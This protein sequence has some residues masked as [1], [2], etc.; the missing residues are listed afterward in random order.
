MD[1]LEH[2]VENLI[3]PNY[4]DLSYLKGFV[5]QIKS[6]KINKELM[7]ELRDY[8]N[9]LDRRRG[10]NWKAIYPWIHDIFVKEL[11]NEH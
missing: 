6:S 8:L 1:K 4:P 7:I 9:E 10:Q 5:T 2:S 3:R 11:V